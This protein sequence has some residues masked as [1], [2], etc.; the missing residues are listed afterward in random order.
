MSKGLR[1]SRW[2]EI[3]GS[4]L[5]TSLFCAAIAVL[6]T[7]VG[8][9]ETFR[10][11]LVIS[12]CIGLSIN[13]AFVLLSDMLRAW[14]SWYLGPIIITAL[15][16]AFGLTIA[17]ITVLGQ[18]WFFFSSNYSSLTAGIFFGVVGFLMFS[19]REQLLQARTQL[20]EAEAARAA[21]ERRNLETELRLL[22]AQIE[23]HFLFNTLGNISSLI[24]SNP[25][26]AE[27]T[28][29]NLSRLLRAS[30]KRTRGETATLGEELEIVTAYLDIQKVRMGDRLETAVIVP[31]YLK[32][33]PLP[34][35]LLQPLVENAV[36]H[37]IDAKIEGGRI[38]VE[39]GIEGEQVII[40]VV[41]TGGGFGSGTQGSGVGLRNVRERL[42][43]LY[44]NKAALDLIENP[45]GG[46]TAEL[47]LPAVAS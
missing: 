47:R 44:G 21:Q 26:G 32:S 13:T 1:S 18:P 35:L 11:T 4:Y 24:R 46:I 16:L 15:G 37:G 14:E 22:Q 36:V 23:P 17:G 9:T 42:S 2:S 43:G 38:G 8:M 19:T 45:G 6:L 5:W 41:D 25:D 10:E 29:Q 39:A 31:D 27:A 34:P 20:A 40:R 7:F 12:F 33:L 30:L 3:A 28:L